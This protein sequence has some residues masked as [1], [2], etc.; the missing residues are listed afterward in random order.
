MSSNAGIFYSR[1]R[2]VGLLTISL[3]NT[4]RKS[5]I[6]F[7]RSAFLHGGRQ[8]TPHF[9]CAGRP[10][11]L[12][13]TLRLILHVYLQLVLWQQKRQ[14]NMSVA[15]KQPICWP[16][17]GAGAG[18]NAC[19]H[20]NTHT[21]VLYEKFLSGVSD[22]TFHLRHS[23]SNSSIICLQSMCAD[24]SHVSWLGSIPFHLQRYIVSP[25][26]RDRLSNSSSII[27]YCAP[28][29]NFK[30]LLPPPFV[31]LH[32]GDGRKFF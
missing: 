28:P 2:R 26:R 4:F 14:D 18:A 23:F 19:A 27:S 25:S 21:A 6:P 10:H 22:L 16:T 8:P 30:S 11:S 1:G 17:A 15:I 7:D 5:N 29:S 9:V 12:L 13:V 32:H 20:T 3:Q 31:W 24:G